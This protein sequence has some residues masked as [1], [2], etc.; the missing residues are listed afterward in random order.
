MLT[1]GLLGICPKEIIIN[2]C[3]DLPISMS[4]ASFLMVANL[5][6]Q[7]IIQQ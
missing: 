5:G 3:N 2:F 4:T 1:T 7:L 6:N